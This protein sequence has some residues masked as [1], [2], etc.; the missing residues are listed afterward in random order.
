MPARRSSKF[1]PGWTGRASAGS[2]GRDMM[3]VVVLLAAEL[4]SKTKSMSRE[5]SGM[6]KAQDIS[7]SYLASS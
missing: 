5:D 6:N 3:S 4:E 7:I 2:T 1:K